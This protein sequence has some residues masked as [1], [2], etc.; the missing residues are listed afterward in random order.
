MQNYDARRCSGYGLAGKAWSLVNPPIG[1][2]QTTQRRQQSIDAQPLGRQSLWSTP[3][4]TRTSKPAGGFSALGAL[5][6]AKVIYRAAYRSFARASKEKRDFK[7]WHALQRR[8]LGGRGVWLA[9]REP[10]RMASERWMTADFFREMREDGNAAFCV[11]SVYTADRE[12]PEGYNPI[13]DGMPAV[14]E[15]LILNTS[16]CS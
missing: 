16:D 8:R 10:G 5:D 13:F 9:G 2:G 3:A 11:K 6:L 14:P 12:C 15:V 1:L 4:L 7:K